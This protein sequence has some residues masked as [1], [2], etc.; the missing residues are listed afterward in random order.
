MK[1]NRQNPLASELTAAPTL[2][3]SEVHSLSADTS[4]AVSQDM[5]GRDAEGLTTQDAEDLELGRRVRQ[6]AARVGLGSLVDDVFS[7]QFVTTPF[8]RRLVHALSAAQGTR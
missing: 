3:A 5:A 7:D 1:W 8:A 6:L 2:E 4:P